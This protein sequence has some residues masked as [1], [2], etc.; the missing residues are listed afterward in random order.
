MFVKALV[1]A[2]MAISV[3]AG[4]SPINSF[5]IVRAEHNV[6]LRSIGWY[7]EVEWWADPKAISRLDRPQES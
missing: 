3:A 6:W 1:P 7:D 4:K 5:S 2:F